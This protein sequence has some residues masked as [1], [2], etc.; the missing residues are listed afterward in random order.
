MAEDNPILKGSVLA[1]RALLVR[2]F[3]EEAFNTTNRSVSSFGGEI[4][5]L[6]ATQA[7]FQR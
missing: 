7:V 3:K 4:Q 1:C 6:V 5:L 2:N